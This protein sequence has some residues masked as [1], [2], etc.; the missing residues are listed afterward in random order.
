MKVN[1]VY[2]HDEGLVETLETFLDRAGKVNETASTLNIHRSTLY[3]RLAKIEEITKTDLHTGS[4]RLLLHLEV[5][6]WRLL[7]L[8]REDSMVSRSSLDSI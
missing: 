4:D 5:K 2:A 3:Y 8:V 1:E 6:L 7:S